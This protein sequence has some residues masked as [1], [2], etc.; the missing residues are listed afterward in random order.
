LSSKNAKLNEKLVDKEQEIAELNKKYSVLEKQLHIL[1]DKS[2]CA[3]SQKISELG[4]TNRH[5]SSQVNVLKS[6]CRE[7][8]TS[9]RNLEEKLKEKEESLLE[10]TTSAAEEPP[11]PS[12]IQVLT[13]TLEKTKK[14]LSEA[15]NSNILLKNEL[16]IAKKCLQNELGNDNLNFHQLLNG[17]SNWRGRAQT[18][19]MLQSKIAE[20][21]EKLESSDFDT[22][23]SSSIIPLKRL[24]SVRKFEMESLS[25]DL[26]QC[27]S[28]LEDVKQ[29]MI[30]LKTHNK[31]LAEELKSFK[32]RCVE[33]MEKTKNDDDYINCLN[34]KISVTKHE[35][36]CEINEIKKQMEKVENSKEEA[37]VEVEKVKCQLENMSAVLSQK[38]DEI[39]S[40][41]LVNEELDSNLRKMT[42]N[43]IVNGVSAQ[44][45]IKILENEKKTLLE[46]AKTYNIQSN[47]KLAVELEQNETINK[48]RV[49]I[50]RLE[51]RV[52]ELEQEK[53][54]NK[55]RYRRVVRIGEYSR[56][57]S[58]CNIVNRPFT[59]SQ[60]KLLSENDR[61]KFK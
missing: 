43:E 54:A 6:K 23:S 36:D 55:L 19:D 26:E 10:L 61:L 1:S 41:K 11:K 59:R 46:I 34:E 15:S 42:G 57:A 16:K 22:V 12:E 33:L 20:L 52:K 2:S 51:G 48:Q 44:D 3:L 31:N 35:C 18:I 25:N 21:R 49:R 7:L 32:A 53:E 58:G 39:S 38:N 50:S 30:A 60:E 14:K 5:L 40:L 45:Y 28:E 8:E 29:K 47:G 9:N 56:I 27:K 4:K 24:E 13:E 17:T 37:R